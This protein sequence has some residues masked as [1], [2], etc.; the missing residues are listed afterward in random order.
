MR[1]YALARKLVEH[2]HRAGTSKHGVVV[3]YNGHVW[4]VVGGDAAHPSLMILHGVREEDVT[5]MRP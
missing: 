1:D 5:W 3:S 4:R 2:G